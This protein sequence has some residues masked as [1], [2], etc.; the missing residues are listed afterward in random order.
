LVMV[1]APTIS[2]PAALRPAPD[3]PDLASRPVGRYQIRLLR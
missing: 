1:T 2:T 3:G